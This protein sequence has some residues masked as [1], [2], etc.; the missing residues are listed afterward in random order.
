MSTRIGIVVVALTIVSGRSALAQEDL[1]EISL[2]SLMNVQVSSVSRHH[3]E[4]RRS[5]AA[6]YVITQED[7]RRSGMTDV[8]ELLRT[9]PG[10]NVARINNSTWAVSARGFNAQYATKLL[11]LVDGRTVY[12]P[13][14]SG[15]YWN[16][17]NIVLDDIER[18]EVIR[19]P[20]ATMW[21]ANAVNGVISIQT[22]KAAS[23]SGGLLVADFG[24]GRPGEGSFRYGG[25]VGRTASYRV[26]G[27]QTTRSAFETSSGEDGQDSWNLTSMGFRLD[28]TPSKR[29]SFTFEGEGHRGVR[30]S[31]QNVLTSLSPLTFEVAG[32]MG[33]RGEYARI[34]WDHAFSA[35]S[36]LTLKAYVNRFHY[37]GYGEEKLQSVDFDLQHN[38]RIGRHQNFTWGLG[39]RDTRD[40][41]P[42]TIAFGVTPSKAHT[43]LTSAFVQD[44]L[45]FLEERLRVTVGS[46][47]EYSSLAG[48]DFQPSVRVAWIPGARNA[49][50]ASASRAVHTASRVERGMHVNVGSFNAGQM[51]G[52]VELLGQKN[53]RSEGL[54]AYEAGY[55]Y[56]ANRRFWTDVSGFYNVYDHLSMVDPADP[57]FSPSP[58]PHL[59]LPLYFGND[60][61]GETYGFEA[62]ANYKVNDRWTVKGSYSRLQMNLRG[63]PGSTAADDIEGQ[64]PRNQIYAGSTL[65]LPKSFELSSH[66]YFTGALPFYGVPGYTRLDAGIAWTGMEHLELGLTGQNLLGAHLESG[67]S[68]SPANAVQRSIFGRVRWRF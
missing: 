26:Y 41:F 49:F 11:V 8:A 50:W 34:Q 19:G 10:V 45:R 65:T 42:E 29:D 53:T 66:A 21:G 4:L 60:A 15:V 9:V 55:R 13:S 25:T 17:Q 2:E 27:R 36:A 67:E 39:R 57:I 43:N 44:E 37:L 16:I 28:W 7:I 22:K 33:N 59:V 62:A 48:A 12:D 5:A 61:S 38:F 31:R 23:T 52:L 58:T 63:R 64:S 46:K 32:L 54:V 35:D 6:V 18:I 20:G 51:F 40:S 14:F 24:S 30:G 3:E 47:V 56:Q 68:P 1:S